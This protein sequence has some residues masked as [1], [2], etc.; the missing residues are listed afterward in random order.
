MSAMA[1]IVKAI[2]DRLKA[3]SGVG[4]LVDDRIW[5]GSVPTGTAKPNLTVDSPTE[6]S[7]FVL[8]GSGYS[9]TVLVHV[10]SGLDA[11]DEIAEII[12][13]VQSA[14]ATD[15]TLGGGMGSVGLR[16]ETGFILPDGNGRTAPLR[17]RAFAMGA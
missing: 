7:R 4:A 14:L 15:L 2:V 16:Y 10:H 6:S 13:A 11:I 3:D 8:G 12:P 5:E 9:D 1:L 17:F